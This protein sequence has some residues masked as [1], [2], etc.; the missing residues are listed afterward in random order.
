MNVDYVI[1]DLHYDGIDEQRNLTVLYQL[2]KDGEPLGVLT[3][4]FE[5][6][7]VGE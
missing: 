2:E 6:E 7:K 3:N 4:N 5:I 1:S